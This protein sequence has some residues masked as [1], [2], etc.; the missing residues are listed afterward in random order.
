M[1]R[2]ARLNMFKTTLCGVVFSLVGCREG[3]AQNLHT[4]H[5]KNARN[6]QL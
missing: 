1:K 5:A 6:A 2:I 3:K 4:N